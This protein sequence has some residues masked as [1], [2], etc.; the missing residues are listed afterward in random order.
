M[1]TVEEI[2]KDLEIVAKLEKLINNEEANIKF[3]RTLKNDFKFVIKID[4][5][6]LDVQISKNKLS[7]V[8]GTYSIFINDYLTRDSVY[9]NIIK[10]TL[11]NLK[12]KYNILFKKELDREQE[13]GNKD[14][15]SY[16]KKIE[17][18]KVH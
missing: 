2:K 6:D 11:E 17:N 8:K 13:N 12:N 10:K 15:N 14:L 18:A 5:Y 16:I 1:K 3:S 7:E 9:D 4:T